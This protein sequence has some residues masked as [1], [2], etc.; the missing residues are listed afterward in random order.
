MSVK[1]RS[2]YSSIPVAWDIYTDVGQTAT[3]AVRNANSVFNVLIKSYKRGAEQKTLVLTLFE[4]ESLP[5]RQMDDTVITISNGKRCLKWGFHNNYLRIELQRFVDNKWKHHC[6]CKL[7]NDTYAAIQTHIIEIRET[8]ESHFAINCL[9]NQLG[10][11][12]MNIN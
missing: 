11:T 7:D 12:P 2:N 9:E 4:F 10:E 3:I 5:F 8:L 1:K 6:V